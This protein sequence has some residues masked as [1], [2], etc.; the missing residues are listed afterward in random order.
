MADTLAL[1]KILRL[2]KNEKQT[3]QKAYDQSTLSFEDIATQLYQLL[4]K[5]EQAEDSYEQYLHKPV[6]L[7]TIKEQLAYIE[8]LSEHIHSLQQEVQQAREDMEAKQDQLLN[9]HI[10]VKK[11]ETIID[12]RHTATRQQLEK[13]EHKT[14]DETSVQQYLKNR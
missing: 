3:A 4:R 2:R 11:Y 12:R 7:E 9:A 8:R 6:Q 13:R 14:M 5:K 1:T 10:E